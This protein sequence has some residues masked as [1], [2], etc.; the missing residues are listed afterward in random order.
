MIPVV[1]GM[2]IHE[3][4]GTYVNCIWAEVLPHLKKERRTMMICNY[5]KD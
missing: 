5:C 4:F 3:F 1:K 2:C